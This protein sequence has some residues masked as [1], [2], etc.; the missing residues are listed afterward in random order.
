MR[1]F[2]ITIFSN[3]FLLLLI[4]LNASD[5]NVLHQDTR[6][7]I[8]LQPIKNLEIRCYLIEKSCLKLWL[9]LLDNQLPKKIL[10]Q[11]KKFVF[12]GNLLYEANRIRV[13]ESITIELILFIE[14]TETHFDVRISSFVH[15]GLLEVEVIRNDI[16]Q[17]INLELV[18]FGETLNLFKNSL[19]QHYP[20]LYNRES[21]S[22]KQSTNDEETICEKNCCGIF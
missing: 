12:T 5:I 2:H 6:N 19:Q 18:Y 7:A 16:F 17:N 10:L 21:I 22:Q 1:H 3:L 11:S 9:F 13:C 4:T 20:W 15:I 14:K 8:I